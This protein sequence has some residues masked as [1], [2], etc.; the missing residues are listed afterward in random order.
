MF[1]KSPKKIFQITVLNLKFEFPAHN[2]KQ[3]T[4][5][6]QVQVGILEY[7]FWRFEKRFAR[8]EKK[9]PLCTLRG[10]RGHGLIS[11][12]YLTAVSFLAVW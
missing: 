11:I 2:S 10:A 7:L 1:V 8:S 4:F 3:L 9:L 5:K 6:F 12:L